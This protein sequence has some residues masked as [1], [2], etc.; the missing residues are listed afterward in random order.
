MPGK[1]APEG[2]E[3]DED[4][5]QEPHTEEE[6]E[7]EETNPSSSLSSSSS[8]EKKK[9]KKKNKKSKKE[10][11]EKKNRE[12]QKKKAAELKA[13]Q[14][15]EAKDKK[16]RESVAKKIGAKVGPVLH[17]LT[18]AIS[19]RGS[20]RLPSFMHEQANSCTMNLKAFVKDSQKAADDLAKIM[21]DMKDIGVQRGPPHRLFAHHLSAPSAILHGSTPAHPQRSALCPPTAI[22][23]L[24]TH[25]AQRSAHPHRPARAP[26]WP[27]SALS[28]LPRMSRRRWAKRR[29]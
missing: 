27:G 8:S 9:K 14:R 26:R 3:E 17:S 25:S 1:V 6:E 23:A 2:L 20:A 15:A 13:K 28:P 21:P 4:E 12:R 24:P 16:A 29:S 7:E 22:S 11:K 5:A 19:R 18:T 10:K